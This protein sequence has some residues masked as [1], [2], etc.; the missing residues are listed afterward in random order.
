MSRDEN[1]DIGIKLDWDTPEN[2][3]CHI[4]APCGS[5]TKDLEEIVE[6]VLWRQEEPAFLSECIRYVPF[7]QLEKLQLELDAAKK[8]IAEAYK[9]GYIN[10]YRAGKFGIE[11]C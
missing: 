1:D 3:S 10:G 5:C 8:E 4:T 11:C 7:I 2:C 6:A 9:E